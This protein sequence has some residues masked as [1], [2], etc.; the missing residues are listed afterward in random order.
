MPL[1]G[2][3]GYPL[4]HSFSK[5]YFEEKFEKEGL[6]DC[7][8]EN[9]PIQRIEDLPALLNDNPDLKGLAVTIPYKQS[10][11]RFLS[12]I[13]N[14]P[15]GMNACNCICIEGDKLTGYNTDVIGFEKSFSPLLQPHHTSA[16]V[17]GSGGAAAA[18][19]FVL[20]KLG[21]AYKVI[22]RK[23]GSDAQISYAGITEELIAQTP[24][25]INTT[26]LGMYPKKDDCPSIPYSAISDKHL[27]Y[28]L[29]Y[30]PEETLFLQKGKEQ[31]ATVKN[32]A[33]M[34]AIQAEANWKKW[35]Q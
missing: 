30:N 9:F 16:L 13:I 15:E 17:F 22:S 10:V 28:D 32:G 23:P 33:D 8:F 20:K 4:S 25:L 21:M 35:N 34:L 1:Y 11:I 5:K 6:K 29:V 18:V 31:G 3:I 2:L 27:L 14:I 24:V 12:S 7:R 19:L 26:P